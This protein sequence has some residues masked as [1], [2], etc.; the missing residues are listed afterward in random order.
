MYSILIVVLELSL[1]FL[2][3]TGLGYVSILIHHGQMEEAIASSLAVAFCILV[4]AWSVSVA[5][6]FLTK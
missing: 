2:A 5:K 6:S 1:H 4:L 3:V